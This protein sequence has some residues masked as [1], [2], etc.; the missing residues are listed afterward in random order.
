MDYGAKVSVLGIF[1]FRAVLNLGMLL[2]ESIAYNLVAF[3]AF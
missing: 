1:N 3:S 2:T